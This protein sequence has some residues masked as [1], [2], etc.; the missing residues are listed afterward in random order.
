MMPLVHP[1]VIKLDLSLI[2]ASPDI[3]IARTINGVLAEVERTGAIILAE[4]IETREHANSALAMGATI[5]QGW[6]FGRPRPLGDHWP[7]KPRPIATVA[8]ARGQEPRIT[9]RPHYARATG[10]GGEQ[11]ALDVAQPAS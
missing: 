4:G 7:R 3:A 8:A 9:V 1:D 2:Q 10:A 5:A 11:A 6:L